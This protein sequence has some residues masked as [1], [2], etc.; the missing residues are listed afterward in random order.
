VGLFEEGVHGCL[1][2]SGHDQGKKGKGERA[3]KSYGV[4]WCGGGQGFVCA[5]SSGIRNWNRRFSFAAIR[6]G[7]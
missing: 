6:L 3:H 4:A 5:F 7:V 1:G 2:G